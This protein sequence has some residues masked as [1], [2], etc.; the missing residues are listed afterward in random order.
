MNAVN[1][2]EGVSLVKK[3]PIDGAEGHAKL[4]IRGS[5]TFPQPDLEFERAPQSAAAER[6]DEPGGAKDAARDGSRG[7]SPPP[8]LDKAGRGDQ[9]G[10]GGQAA[11]PVSKLL[12]G[13]GDI[14][15]SVEELNL[16]IEL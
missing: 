10:E 11:R 13:M 5:V 8:P 9:S 12:V 3:V 4:E 6:P 15:I 2:M 7:L 14:D 1:I 16:L